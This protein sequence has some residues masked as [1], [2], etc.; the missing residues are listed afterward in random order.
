MTLHQF[1]QYLFLLHF[2]LFIFS[3]AALVWES[4]RGGPVGE[5]EKVREDIDFLDSTLII[6]QRR[7]FLK[8]QRAVVFLVIGFGKRFGVLRHRQFHRQKTNVLFKT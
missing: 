6:T 1:C 4:D 3:L 7:L 8:T 2:N 5:A